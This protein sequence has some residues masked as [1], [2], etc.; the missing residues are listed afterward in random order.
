MA[1]SP[2][3]LGLTLDFGVTVAQLGCC[4]FPRP[5][6]PSEPV[7]KAGLALFFWTEDGRFGAQEECHLL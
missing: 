7:W 1:P 3:C 5:Q 2:A 4:L 6:R